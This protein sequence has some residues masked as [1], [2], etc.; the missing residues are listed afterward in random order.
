M[1]VKFRTNYNNQGEKITR[2][3]STMPGMTVPDQSMTIQEIQTRF[4]SGI[5]VSNAKIPVYNGEEDIW[6]GKDPKSL[7]FVEINATLKNRIEEV[8]EA[9]IRVTKEVTERQEKAAKMKA[10]KEAKEIAEEVER[11]EKKI[12]ELMNQRQRM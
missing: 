4:A 1:K 7:D 6:E 2:K 5:P 8:K 3:K 10:E 9:K 12:Q 11:R